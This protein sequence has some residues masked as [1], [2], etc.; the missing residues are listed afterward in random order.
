MCS[1]P[2]TASEEALI[3]Q[4][5]YRDPGRTRLKCK[6]LKSMISEKFKTYQMWE[7]CFMVR[8]DQCRKVF[9]QSDAEQNPSYKS[10]L[11]CSKIPQIYFSS[12]PPL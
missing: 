12:P 4:G 10:D 9:S 11:K 2:P 8:P 6:R 7:K 3:G 1:L 5:G